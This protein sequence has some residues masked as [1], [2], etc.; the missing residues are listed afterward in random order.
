M[1]WANR[2]TPA[3]GEERA[4][5]LPLLEAVKVRTG[6]RGRPRTRLQGMATEKG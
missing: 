6:K 4:R 1:P 3:N 5:V 2:P